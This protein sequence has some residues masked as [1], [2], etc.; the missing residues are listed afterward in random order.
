MLSLTLF[1]R[2]IQYLVKKLNVN[3]A[4]S[5]ELCLLFS[6]HIMLKHVEMSK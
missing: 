5:Q 4:S 2:R 6:Y 1:Q 3:S